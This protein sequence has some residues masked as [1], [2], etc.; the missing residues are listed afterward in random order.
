M[1]GVGGWS[2]GLGGGR[3]AVRLPERVPL[4]VTILYDTQRPHR[5]PLLSGYFAIAR[6]SMS[7]SIDFSWFLV[8]PDSGARFSWC[9]YR[10]SVAGTLQLVLVPTFCCGD[11]SAGSRLVNRRLHALVCETVF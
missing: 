2:W 11:I 6:S 3:E 7:W 10:R 5:G 8:R 4:S 9:S 1:E